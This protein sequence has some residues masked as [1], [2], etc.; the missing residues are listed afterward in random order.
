[1]ARRVA[2]LAFFLAPALSAQ[3]SGLAST[4]D[5]SSLYF[6]S[7]LRLKSLG[8]PL[9][10]KVYVATPSG[11]SLFRAREP[12]AVPPDAPP[13]TVGGFADYLAAE[14]SSAGTVALVYRA[15]Q[16]GGCSYP[17]NTFMTRIVTAAGESDLPGIARLSSGGRYALV[18]R[19][20]TARIFN[21]VSVS[22][23]DL[24]SGTQAPV[25]VTGPEFPQYIQ[26]HYTGGRVIADNGTAVLA[27]TDGGTRNRGYIVKPGADPAPFPIPD[28]LPLIIDASGTKILYQE[29][30]LNLIDLRTLA[31][32]LLVPADEPVSGLGMSDDARRLLFLR[33]G[34]AHVLDTTTL[35][36]LALTSDP[37]QVTQAAISSDG[38][39]VFAVTGIG[40]LLKINV[41]DGSQSEIIGRTPYLSPFN[42]GV[43]PGLATTLTGSGLADSVI[44]GTVPLNDWLGSVTM[45]IGERKV[46]M[47]Q[48]TPNSVSF[49]V[50]WDIQADGGSIRM[51]AEARGEHTPFYFPEAEATLSTPVNFP[52]AGA[53]L[54]QDWTRTYVGPI[55]TGEIIHVYAIGF[56]PVSPAVPDGAAAPSAEPFS[57]ITQTLA[58]S[59]AEILFAGLAPGAIERVYQID[60]RIG[61][62]PGYQKFGCSLGALNFTFLT[63]DIVP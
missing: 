46:P 59:N 16:S 61:P 39:T 29:Q 28:G 55:N 4:A 5:G 8:Q 43:V 13:C 11:V 63:L 40:R 56:G 17:P 48:L 45:W 10:G 57:R 21:P 34:Q 3:F 24:R 49:I 35:I 41:D 32:T 33:D 36:D 15:S 19:G 51:L 26:Q 14:T 42:R 37:A 47:T 18:F 60:I 27:I 58:C 2:L 9:N 23:L 6:A 54:R 22:F 20:A 38:K 7:T 1:M 52:V 50:P 62:T 31:S 30:G 12:S 25:N 44:N 53:I